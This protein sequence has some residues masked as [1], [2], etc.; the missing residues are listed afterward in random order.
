MRKKQQSKQQ[1]QLL[2]KKHP[3]SSLPNISHICAVKHSLN[4]NRRP[5][6]APARLLAFGV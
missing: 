1:N 3:S 5:L 2:L 6:A 4:R